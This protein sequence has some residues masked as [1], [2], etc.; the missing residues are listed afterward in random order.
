MAQRAAVTGKS[1]AQLPGGLGRQ[2]PGLGGQLVPAPLQG[3]CGAPAQGVAHGGST[4]IGKQPPG[5][6]GLLQRQQTHLPFQH[7]A[8]GAAIGRVI[9]LAARHGAQQLQHLAI[10]LTGLVVHRLSLGGLGTHLLGLGP[11]T[12]HLG[13]RHHGFKLQLHRLAHA[14][15]HR[16]QIQILLGPRTAVS[17]A[18]HH[19]APGGAVQC[20][21]PV[22]QLGLGLGLLH[23]GH[24]FAGR[25]GCRRRAHILARGCGSAGL[26]AQRQA[27]SLEHQ[28][29]R[30]LALAPHG[31]V[32]HAAP[33]V[34]LAIGHHRQGDGHFIRQVLR[35]LHQGLYAPAFVQRLNVR[36]AHHALG[37]QGLA[38][39]PGAVLAQSAQGVGVK[40]EGVRHYRSNWP[41]ALDE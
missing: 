10:G 14:A 27:G 28:R 16:Q 17:G 18:K 7:R 21:Q 37:Q 31:A 5:A 34:H 4:R 33:V 2:S 19:I 1:S 13:V 40:P 24:A 11:A 3:A 23:S 39:H 8:G 26:V 32:A 29:H 35:A 38:T 20:G 15:H 9:R 41:L 6:G 22:H 30:V 36:F 12:G 25:L